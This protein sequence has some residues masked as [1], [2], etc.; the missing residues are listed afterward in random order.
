MQNETALSSSPLPGQG[1]KF[2]EDP[3]KEAGVRSDQVVR[4]NE[5]SSP[6]QPARQPAATVASYS[7][8]HSAP[9]LPIDPAGP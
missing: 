6:A 3:G 9:T 1:L 4:P 5:L 7:S 8:H 2:T